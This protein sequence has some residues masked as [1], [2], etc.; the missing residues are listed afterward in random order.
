ML[1]KKS[2]HRLPSITHPPAPIDCLLSALKS[3]KPPRTTADKDKLLSSFGPTDNLKARV[4]GL[5][6]KPA[7]GKRHRRQIMLK[8]R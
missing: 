2:M 7:N 6:A 3:H 8:R 1:Q 4:Q 5:C